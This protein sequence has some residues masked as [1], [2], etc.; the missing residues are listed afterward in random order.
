MP[1]SPDDALHNLNAWYESY[2]RAY[3]GWCNLASCVRAALDL[4]GVGET[5][6]AWSVLEDALRDHSPPVDG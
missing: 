4:L 2:R 5:C 6:C 3:I 1:E